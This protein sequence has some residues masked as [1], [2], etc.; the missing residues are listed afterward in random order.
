MLG[1]QHIEH[2][3]TSM[4]SSKGKVQLLRLQAN[5]SRRD[6]LAKFDGRVSLALSQKYGITP[7]PPGGNTNKNNE[8]D[9][10]SHSGSGNGGGGSSNFD[11]PLF[12]VFDWV[13]F[14]RKVR[15]Q[16]YEQLKTDFP[17]EFIYIS[18]SDDFVGLQGAA[19]A[20][21]MAFFQLCVYVCV[22]GRARARSTVSV[23]F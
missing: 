3:A 9:S 7:P 11:P 17:G 4:S 23:F 13:A 22:C 2:V 5:K 14:S 15:Q 20:M 16:Y 12:V 21:L 10:S 18:A 1:I 8:A 19:A 6:N